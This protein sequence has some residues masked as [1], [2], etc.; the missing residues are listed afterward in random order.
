MRFV[1]IAAT[2]I[3]AASSPSNAFSISFDILY[4]GII[5]V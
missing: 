3:R 5:L 2:K 1:K 4:N